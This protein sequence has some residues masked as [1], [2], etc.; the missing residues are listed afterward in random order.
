[1]FNKE[2]KDSGI[3]DA[4]TII[5]PSIKVKGNFHGE[6]NMVIEGIVEGSIKTNKNL[7]VGERAVIT[8]SIEA[9]EA[10]IGGKVNGNGVN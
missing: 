1:M 7:L 6:G 10:K 5:G 2:Q 4:E 3:K 8:A 9:K